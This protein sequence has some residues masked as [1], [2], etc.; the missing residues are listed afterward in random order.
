MVE[1]E[2]PIPVSKQKLVP[3]D[4]PAKHHVHLLLRADGKPFYIGKG[5]DNRRPCHYESHAIKNRGQNLERDMEIH[6]L[7]A[8]DLDL[9]IRP[10]FW[11]DDYEEVCDEQI[12]L[13]DHYGRDTLTNK[14]SGGKGVRGVQDQYAEYKTFRERYKR[15]HNGNG[16]SPEALSNDE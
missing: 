4:A 3:G 13:I 1:T 11:S 2:K 16:D 9:I 14:T 10:V 5:T 6:R 7:W 8:A 15:S 12:R